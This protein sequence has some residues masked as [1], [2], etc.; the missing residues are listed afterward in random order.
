[1][2]LRK[3]SDEMIRTVASKVS[4]GEAKPIPEAKGRDIEK[5]KKEI[6]QKLAPRMIDQMND[7][8]IVRLHDFLFTKRLFEAAKKKGV[9]PIEEL[10]P[11][12]NAA[13]SDNM[14]VEKSTFEE[15]KEEGGM[16]GDDPGQA[17]YELGLDAALEVDDEAQTTYGKSQGHF[18]PAGM[19]KAYEMTEDGKDIK[20]EL[21]GINAPYDAK[22][23]TLSALV[24]Q[25]ESGD[26]LV[27]SGDTTPDDPKP[28]I[29]KLKAILA[30]L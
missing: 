3:V 26:M 1:M 16:E 14:L 19:E 9:N 10:L 7:F 2:D 18:S 11:L 25:L 20:I 5:M 27:F 12:L 21:A 13:H 8:F 24:K 6:K 29:S 15:F 28:L 23:I 30:K 17:I 22:A 4:E